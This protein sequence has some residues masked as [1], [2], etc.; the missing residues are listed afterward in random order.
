M[1]E[2]DQ[3]A[4]D[5]H[6]PTAAIIICIG[7]SEQKRFEKDIV[8]IGRAADNDLILNENSELSSYHAQLEIRNG[9]LW[10]KDL[11]SKNGIYL[12][13]HRMKQ[14]MI[15][16]SKD[17]IRLGPNGTDWSAHAID[18]DSSTFMVPAP[19]ILDDSNPAI[20]K[21]TLEHAIHSVNK[22]NRRR[23][24]ALS[25]ILALSVVALILSDIF[26]LKKQHKNIAQSTAQ[27]AQQVAENEATLTELMA[28][29]NQRDHMI[30]EIMN[31]SD[32][33]EEDRE[34]QLKETQHIIS[35][36]ESKVIQAQNSRQQ[37]QAASWSSL[38][39]SYKHS[40]F[41]IIARNP[42]TKRVGLG[43]AFLIDSQNSIGTLATNAHVIDMILRMPQV[44]IFQNES[45][46]ACTMSAYA[47]HPRF[48]TSNSPDVGLLRI[49]SA[50]ITL[51]NTTVL[52]LADKN[53]IHNT[54][55]GSHLG[56]IGFPGELQKQYLKNIE[57]NSKPITGAVATFKEG[58]LGRLTDYDG[59]Q[60]NRNTLI[61]HSASLSGGTSGSPMFNENG[62]VIGMSSSSM[63]S[64]F[65]LGKVRSKAVLSAAEIAYAIRIDELHWLIENAKWIELGF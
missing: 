17:C 8:R 4:H 31:H 47:K 5:N 12:N 59:Q 23:I 50:E 52:P 61:Q 24:L 28:E 32:L 33:S 48:T 58:W 46:K 15:I 60:S 35:Q 2:L 21:M 34:L 45:G 62:I 38:Y 64:T 16:R 20:E 1:N 65:Q 36:L 14:D 49:T 56:T 51:S 10:L 6:S 43:T 3:Q 25:L 41:L 40:I 9:I 22:K 7:N 55:V 11:D 63:T 39:K 37:Q 44:Y 54:S 29:I 30:S 18:S 13:K 53:I 26:T 42:K 27:Q 57:E 19:D